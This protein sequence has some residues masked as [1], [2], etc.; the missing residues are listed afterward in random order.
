MRHL[1]ART[2]VFQ[3]FGPQINPFKHNSA[4]SLARFDYHKSAVRLPDGVFARHSTLLGG[5]VTIS[6]GTLQALLG[7]Q[8]DTPN[9]VS[10]CRFVLGVY[11]T[12]RITLRTPMPYYSHALPLARSNRLG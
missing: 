5:P 6:S 8:R 10:D 9:G 4:A 2:S 7:T 12:P 1:C 3:R 11:D